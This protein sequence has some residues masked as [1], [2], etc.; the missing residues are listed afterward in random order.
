MRAINMYTRSRTNIAGLSRMRMPARNFRKGLTRFLGAAIETN[1]AEFP[2][3]RLLLRSPSSPA[4]C[5]VE[6]AKILTWLIRLSYL[7]AMMSRIRASNS[8]AGTKG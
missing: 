2:S 8:T 5:H 1:V 6:E 7:G 3:E 4:T